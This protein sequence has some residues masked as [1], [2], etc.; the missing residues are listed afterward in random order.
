MFFSFDGVDGA[1]KTTQIGLFADWLRSQG[2][3]VVT[4][5]DPGSTPLGEQLRKILLEHGTE[6]AV[7]A[8]SEMFLYMAARAELTAT[9]I[10][11]ALAADKTV[12]SDRFLLANVVYQGYAGGLDVAMLW[13]VGQI[14]TGGLA[15]D[16][17]FVL[18]MSPVDAQRRI[19]RALDRMERQDG[20]YRER[21]RQGFLREAQRRPDQVV[22]IEATGSIAQVHARIC[23][24]ASRCLEKRA[25]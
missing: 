25:H 22:V 18:D 6:V 21:L 20:A 15:P 7:A 9:L 16:L 12:I 8:R 19:A 17:I 5:R 11:P 1:G 4:C 10:G 2:H 23:T 24:A 14:A 3:D 13:Q